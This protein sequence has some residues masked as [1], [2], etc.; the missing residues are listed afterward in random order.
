M[1][2]KIERIREAVFSRKRIISNAYNSEKLQEYILEKTL[3]YAGNADL[4]LDSSYYRDRIKYFDFLKNSNNPSVVEIGGGAGIDFFALRAILKVEPS[5]WVNIENQKMVDVCSATLDRYPN[6]RVVTS[7]H[8]E[9]CI[10]PNFDLLY[11]NSALQYLD[12]QEKELER[13]LRYQPKGVVIART[14]YIKESI[15]AS[16]R[17]L[18]K[19]HFRDNGPDATFIKSQNYL[20]EYQARLISFD[21]ICKLLEEHGYEIEKVS[22]KEYWDEKPNELGKYEIGVFDIFAKHA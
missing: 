14:P 18:Q 21:R 7:D 11:A 20:V 6:L 13:L 12:D 22:E 16:V 15:S 19:S 17:I 1:K 10:N 2:V 8:Y 5:M 3:S 9:Q 4:F